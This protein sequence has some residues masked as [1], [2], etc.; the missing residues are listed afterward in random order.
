MKPLISLIFKQ[1]NNPIIKPEIV[2]KRPI[3]KPLIIKIFRS[4]NLETP[5]T[6][7]I[8]ISFV[9]DETNIII[10]DIKLKVATIIIKVKIINMTFLSTSIALN[11]EGLS[12]LQSNTL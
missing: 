11:R 3:N 8:P 9:F 2:P 12:C 10:D 6:L 5:S 4:W 7:K 1:N